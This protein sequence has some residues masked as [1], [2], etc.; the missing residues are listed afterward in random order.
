[1]TKVLRQFYLFLIICLLVVSTN[2]GLINRHVSIQNADSENLLGLRDVLMIPI[3]F[4]GLFVARGKPVLNNGLAAIAMAFL[5]LTPIAICV[6]FLFGA[7]PYLLLSDSVTMATWGLALFLGQYLQDPERL[8]TLCRMIIGLGVAISV[9]VF[10][11]GA[12][13]GTIALVTPATD[14]LATTLRSTPTGWP[15]MMMAA[16]C[17]IASIVQAPRCKMIVTWWRLS[18]LGVIILASLLTQSRTLLAGIGLSTAMY[19]VLCGIFTAWRTRWIFVTA[20]V[21]LTAIVIPIALLLGQVW[22]RSDFSEMFTERYAVLYSS[23]AAQGQMDDEGRLTELHTIVSECLPESPIFGY[24]LTSP[25]MAGS[26]FSMVHCAFGFF[27]LRYG[28]AGFFLWLVF[29]A[30]IVQSTAYFVRSTGPVWLLGQAF[31]LAMLNMVIC[32][33]FG[34]AFGTPYG[35]QQTM[36]GLGALIA[37]QQYDR[38]FRLQMGASAGR[39]PATAHPLPLRQPML[40]PPGYQVVATNCPRRLETGSLSVE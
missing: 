40:R 6:G 39:L 27:F 1:M 11:E 28:L 24:G 23:D 18:L 7:Q 2:I 38:C 3:M 21:G 35:V 9:G 5:G 4:F 36:I 29:I 10:I 26:D 37:C 25:Y 33:S 22:M 30:L 34:N 14:A 17:L 19:L 8:G 32:A 31:S 15:V 13:G 12:S 20:V 16:S